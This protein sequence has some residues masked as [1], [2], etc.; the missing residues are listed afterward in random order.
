MNPLIVHLH[1]KRV[2]ML[3]DDGQQLVFQYGEA[4]LADT[5]ALPLSRQLPLQAEP[6]VGQRVNVFFGGLLPEA[7]SRDQIARNLG[8]SAN[9]DFAMLERIGGECAG[10]IALVPEEM[11]GRAPS[12]SGVRWLSE[13]EVIEIMD[14]LPHQ[15]L[16]AGEQGLRLSLAGAQIKLPVVIDSTFGGATS[17]ALPLGDT[18]STHIIKPEPLRFPGLAENEAWCMALAR[19][20]GLDTAEARVER[21]GN[22][23]C[24][25]S[26]RYDRVQGASGEIVRRLHQ[27]DFCQA[28]GYP[29]SRKYQQEGGPSLRE[30][31]QMIRD[32]ST[33]PVLDIR[34]MLDSV[35][36]SAVTGNADAHGKNHSF[37]Y[38]QDTR[39]MAPLY[40]QVCTMAWPELSTSLSM[41]IGSAA[42][43]AEVSPEH[44]KQLCGIAKLGWP[45][46]CERIKTMCRQILD[47]TGEP[48]VLPEL[49]DTTVREI[50]TKRAERML[51]LMEKTAD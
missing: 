13:G 39:R 19:R 40:D 37:L 33:T 27:E 4:W 18:P 25:I 28:L 7:D 38:T 6:F 9:N 16:L 49:R 51:S 23:P 1:G 44:F 20:I 14:R 31:F 8:I 11:E 45:M 46:A 50:V 3:G 36:F 10:A 15:P 26:K 32:W 35:I 17:L 30:C 12:D 24:L 41:K 47:A 5:G 42:S 29:S 48:Q 21:I 2:G 43:L 34:H 22:V